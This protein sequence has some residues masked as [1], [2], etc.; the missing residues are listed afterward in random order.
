MMVCW[1]EADRG[2]GCSGAGEE[3]V[4]EV[5]KESSGNGQNICQLI[6]G[7]DRKAVAAA[8]K[9]ADSPSF[10]KDEAACWAR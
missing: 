3:M 7:P 8:K 2:R 9:S 6:P 10:K 4:K 5:G 1:W